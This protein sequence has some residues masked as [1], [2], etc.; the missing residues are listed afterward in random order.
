MTDSV[1]VD[2][3]AWIVSFCESGNQKLKDYLKDA[4][5]LDRV[6]TTNIVVLE[7]LQGCKTRKEYD[8]LKEMLAVLPFAALNDTAW[9][10]AYEA[11]YNLRRKGITFPTVDI[12]ICSIAKANGLHVL[13]HD[14]HLQS[15]AREMGIKSVDFLK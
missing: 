5:D 4:I 2:T 10:I 9:I 6:A 1:L 3:S 15:L 12:L 7:L 14:G 11:G 13:H 8:A